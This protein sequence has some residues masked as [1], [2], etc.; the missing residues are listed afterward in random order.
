M[1]QNREEQILPQGSQGGVGSE[2]WQSGLVINDTVI[3]IN[4]NPPLQGWICRKD[5]T[6]P[7]SYDK[8]QSLTDAEEIYRM[9]FV[10]SA[11]KLPWHVEGQ[12]KLSQGI[13]S[14]LA[15]DDYEV[16]NC[17]FEVIQV[18]FLPWQIQTWSF[19]LVS[20]QIYR[21]RT[22]CFL[23]KGREISH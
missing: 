9:G 15:S 12:R 23:P 1:E 8:I 16:I 17:T 13:E 20:Y 3:V 4:D 6:S 10:G 14:W 21:K 22:G 19:S 7:I 18:G 2:R 11:L 5:S